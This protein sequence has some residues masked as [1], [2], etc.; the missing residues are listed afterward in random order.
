MTPATKDPEVQAPAA[1]QPAAKRPEL[2]AP[3]NDGLARAKV[4]SALHWRK[5]REILGETLPKLGTELVAGTQE[6]LAIGREVFQ[7][8]AHMAQHKIRTEGYVKAI[9][10]Q[11]AA[12]KWMHNLTQQAKIV[13][14]DCHR[15]IVEYLETHYE[16]RYQTLKQRI[17]RLINPNKTRQTQV[18]TGESNT[19]IEVPYQIVEEAQKTA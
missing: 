18:V 16:D 6:L 4:A 7:Q 11:K 12:K 8:I 9:M 1:E 2:Q 19:A 10:L 13:W 14:Q 15:S 17:K 5:I 3:L